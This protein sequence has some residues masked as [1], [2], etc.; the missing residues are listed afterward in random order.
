M[1]NTPI[2][3]LPPMTSLPVF[4]AVGRHMSVTTAARE[5]NVTPSAISRQ[6]RN[7]E[8]FIGCQLFERVHRRIIFTPEGELLW[9][10]VRKALDEIREA[11]SEVSTDVARR[12]LL[13]SCPRMFLQKRIV[14]LL[15]DF[16]TQ[17]PDLSVRFITDV[18]DQLNEGVDA[19]IVVGEHSVELGYRSEF[20]SEGN[21]SPVCSPAYLA[22]A[23]A[24]SKPRDLSEHTLL[25]SPAFSKNWRLW[26]GED[27]DAV[28]ASARFIDFESSGLELPAALSGLG[29]AIVRDSQVREELL[30]GNLV[31]LLC[32]HV[33]REHYALVYP[34]TKLRFNGFNRFRKWIRSAIST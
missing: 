30:A 25:R 21:L 9:G 33:V 34:E 6:L 20:L 19:A 1:A 28:F 27:A 26:L 18:P 29:I 3:K 4:E 24:L 15:V 13:V 14:P 22:S 7:L 5:L 12:P 2:T 23:P 8:E 31:W 32:K 16:Y 11:T 17:H 10:K